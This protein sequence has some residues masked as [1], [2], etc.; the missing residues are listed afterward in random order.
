[1]R[2]FAT[3]M[4]LIGAL[5]PASLLARSADNDLEIWLKQCAGAEGYEALNDC[6]AKL[7]TATEKRGGSPSQGASTVEAK[8]LGAIEICQKAQA[9]S[10]LQECVRKLAM[11]FN[12][13]ERARGA[14]AKL[15]TECAKETDDNLRACIEVMAK[16]AT[17]PDEMLKQPAETVNAELLLKG[18]HRAPDKESKIDGARTIA[19][20]LLADAQVTTDIGRKVWP[21]LGIR[22]IDNVTSFIVTVPGFFVTNAVAVAYRLDKDKPVT[23]KWFASDSH[24]AMGLW[25][26]GQAIPFIRSLLDHDE[27]VFRFS[28]YRKA[29]LEMTFSLAGLDKA[30]EPIR[31]G[32]KW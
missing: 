24:N 20:G 12:A 25:N 29:D 23:Q 10:V 17:I 15:A 31:T 21:A 16:I 28:P 26:G 1:M 14:M 13:H 6:I 32:C 5:W 4:L 8:M 3:A 11:A 30:I 9:A 18:W 22:C 27:M 7:M 2:R 19:I